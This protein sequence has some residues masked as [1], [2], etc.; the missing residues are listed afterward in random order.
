MAKPG[1]MQWI[2]SGGVLAAAIGAGLLAAV[3]V[4]L[5]AGNL[6]SR[7]ELGAQYFYRF[8]SDMPTGTQIQAASLERV[9]I[10]KPFAEAFEGVVVSADANDERVQTVIGRKVPR[11]MKK[12][13]L[14]WW[15]DYVPT[16]VVKA[17]KIPPRYEMITIRID[18]NASLG[19]QL[20]PGS[21]VNIRGLF[22]I[23]SDLRNPQ[24]KVEDVLKNIQ[25]VAL[26]GSTAPPEKGRTYENLQIVIPSAQAKLMAEV[27]NAVQSGTFTLGVVEEG[28]TAEPKIDDAVIKI[29]NR[30]RTGVPAAPGAAPSAPAPP[31]PIVE[32]SAPPVP[33]IP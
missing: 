11:P 14:L 13:M 27:K 26:N 12:G 2:P 10:P 4:H 21:Y 32:P 28:S 17:I 31:P 33:E 7:Y 22:N 19:A 15:S 23:S 20:Q 25:V 9:Q 16:D 18:P 29:I 5:Y 3:L 8:K 30:P 6:K 24:Y 1:P